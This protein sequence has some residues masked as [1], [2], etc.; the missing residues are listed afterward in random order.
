MA[1]KQRAQKN[2]PYNQRIGQV[3]ITLDVVNHLKII[4]ARQV[5]MAQ[6]PSAPI[7]K[8]LIE[9]G[10]ITADDLNRALSIQKDL[11]IN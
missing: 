9:L 6:K 8:I 5:Q 4:K 3:L 2:R 11:D 1:K 10:Y 7:G